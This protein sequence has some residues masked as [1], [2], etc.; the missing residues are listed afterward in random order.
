VQTSSNST[1]LCQEDAF[2]DLQRDPFPH[3]ITPVVSQVR[4]R[5][6]NKPAHTVK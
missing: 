1:F 4:H 6:S 3:P 5:K 2:T